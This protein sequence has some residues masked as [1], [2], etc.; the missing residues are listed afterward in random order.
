V[1]TIPR[2]A[3]VYRLR[4]TREDLSDDTR[5]SSIDTVA[6]AMCIIECGLSVQLTHSSAAVRRTFDSSALPRG[7]PGIVPSLKGVLAYQ[8]L[9]GRPRI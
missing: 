8:R 6:A 3:V 4:Q 7:M 1:V 9:K 2:Q 5:G